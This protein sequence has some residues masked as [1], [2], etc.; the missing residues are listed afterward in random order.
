MT[1]LSRS[2]VKGDTCQAHI[3]D[4]YAACIA[5]LT[6]DIQGHDRAAINVSTGNAYII[7]NS[8]QWPNGTGIRIEPMTVTQ[9]FDY[10]IKN[11]SVDFAYYCALAI[12]HD[13]TVGTMQ[14]IN[15]SGNSFT[16]DAGSQNIACVYFSIDDTGGIWET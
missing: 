11:N 12:W 13:T 16:K 7:G 9:M 1:G 6:S 2:L 15:I 3:S 10:N 4:N 5:G 14:R 8:I